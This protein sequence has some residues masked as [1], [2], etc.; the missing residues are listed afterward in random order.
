[1]AC[2]SGAPFETSEAIAEEGGN[3]LSNGEDYEDQS[4]DHD[5]TF[6]SDEVNNVLLPK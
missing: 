2:L 1:M 3:K 6:S 4:I 5:D